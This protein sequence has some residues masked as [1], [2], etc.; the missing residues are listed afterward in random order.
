LNG[1]ELRDVNVAKEFLDKYIAEFTKKIV[2]LISGYADYLFRAG[3]YQ[4]SINKAKQMESLVQCATYW[5]LP[6]L[7]AYNY[8][9]LGDTVS[10]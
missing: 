5:Q 4:E 2:K 3:K 8:E 7:Y 10:V 6:I 1:T 9:R